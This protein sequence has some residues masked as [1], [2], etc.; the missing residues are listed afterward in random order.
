[1]NLANWQALDFCKRNGIDYSGSFI[2][3]TNR[4]GFTYTLYSESDGSSI[5]TITFHKNSVP[6]FTKAER[7]APRHS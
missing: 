7:S 1:M 6:T 4:R 2:M 5:V 3:K